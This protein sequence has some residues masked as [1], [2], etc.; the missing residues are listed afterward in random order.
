MRSQYLPEGA[1]LMAL[2]WDQWRDWGKNILE[3]TGERALGLPLKGGP[4]AALHHRLLQ[5]YLYPSFTGA[6]NTEFA[7]EKGVAMWDWLKDAWQYINPNATWSQ[8]DLPLQN[9][10]V[11]VAWD[12]T[13]RLIEALRAEPEQFVAFPVA[14]RPRGPW[15]HARHRGPRCPQDGLRSRW[16]QGAHQALPEA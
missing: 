3:A 7:T 4:G 11:Q 16:R 10:E 15:L 12:H 1:D 9:R 2:T 5:G 8:M 14:G 13:A 6:V